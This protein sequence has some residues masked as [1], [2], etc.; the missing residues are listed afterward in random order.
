MEYEL[1]L[2]CGADLPGKTIPFTRKHFLDLKDLNQFRDRFSN[3]GIYHTQMIYVNPVWTKNSRD[4]MII[5]AAQSYKISGFYMDFDGSGN[6]K[7]TFDLV[8]E[9]VLLSIRCLH[10]IY[11]VPLEAFRIYFSGSKGIHMVIPYECL[12]IKPNQHIHQ[13]F[14]RL[15]SRIEKHLKHSTL[16][17]K[18]YDD[19][20]LFR[21]TNSIHLKTGLFKIPLQLSE[22]IALDYDQIC[23]L[24]KEQRTEW[25]GYQGVCHRLVRQMEHELIEIEDEKKP[26]RT[27]FTA[28]VDQEIPACIATMETKLFYE[29]IDQRN[30]S[31]AALASFYFQRQWDKQKVLEKMI[32]WNETQCIPSLSM[33]E[34]ERT[35]YSVFDHGY[36][37]GCESF[38]L[39]SGV[40]IG[41]KCPYF[42]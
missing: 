29:T 21:Y 2:E 36:T 32:V 20:R 30:N 24:A 25:S 6:P 35:V 3:R 23:H 10:R 31:C 27:M 14:K 1:V 37:Y 38:E 42:K 34:V 13:A 7:E 26:K 41:K 39:H 17:V 33:R 4:Q 15:A 19:K 11:E 9:D 40:C 22:L 16:D 8:K 12:Q 18:I 28:D 5:D